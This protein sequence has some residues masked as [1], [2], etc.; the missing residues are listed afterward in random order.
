MVVVGIDLGIVPAIPKSCSVIEVGEEKNGDNATQEIRYFSNG[1]PPELY[2]EAEG[3]LLKNVGLV[4]VE[5]RRV[6]QASLFKRQQS[7]RQRFDF[8]SVNQRP[9]VS[10]AKLILQV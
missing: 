9:V 2:G 8:R 5:E 4:E 1:W 7:S 10:G 3:V 6:K